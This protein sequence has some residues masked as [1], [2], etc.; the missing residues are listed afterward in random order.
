MI[1]LLF[2]D[3]SLTTEQF[4]NSALI[5]FGFLVLAFCLCLFFYFIFYALFE[6]FYKEHEHLTRNDVGVMIDNALKR[7]RS[8]SCV[9]SLN[10]QTSK[11]KKKIIKSTD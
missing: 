8:R 10:A 9:E 4:I 6:H 3:A 1:E 11:N 2:S 7:E 5:L